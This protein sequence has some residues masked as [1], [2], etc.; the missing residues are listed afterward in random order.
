MYHQHKQCG[1]AKPCANCTLS[2]KVSHLFESVL[3]TQDSLLP[4]CDSKPSGSPLEM[5]AVNHTRVH[6]E[7]RADSYSKRS[8]DGKEDMSLPILINAVIEWTSI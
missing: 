4:F 2:P 6:Q 8:A 7:N 5:H 3:T 1:A